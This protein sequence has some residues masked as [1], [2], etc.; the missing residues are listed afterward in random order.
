MPRGEK[1]TD[2][3]RYEKVESLKKDLFL[4]I[5]N[6]PEKIS[7]NLPV[8]FGHVMSALENAFPDIDDATHD[9]FI[10]SVAYR[11][12]I[13]SAEAKKTEFIEKIIRNAI[14]CKRKKTKKSTLKVFSGIKLMDVGKYWE[15]ISYFGDLWKYDARIGI[16]IAFCYYA[17]SED[18][19]KSSKNIN[20][21]AGRPSQYELASREILLELARAQPEI[22][23]LKQIDIRDT[24]IMDQAFWLMINKAL[25]WF[26]SERWFLKIGIAKAKND[27]NEI[28]RSDLLSYAIEKYTNDLDFMREYYYYKLEKRDAMG[29]SGIVKQM[30]QQNPDNLEPVYYG[31]KLS[32]LS[33]SKNTYNQYRKDALEKGIPHY[34]IQLYDLAIYIM[35][36]EK[37][38]ADLQLKL[39]KKKFKSL[40]FYLAVIEYLMKDIFSDDN[41]RKKA[42]KNVFFDSLDRYS[43]QVIKIQE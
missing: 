5:D 23:R 26:P 38:E 14:R 27:G 35:R 19:E 12:M 29:A 39:I 7:N 36:E 37:N 43:M 25:E 34:L 9:D 22:N 1:L 32:L 24:E 15:A 31:I 28:K 20:D 16:Y 30:I 2:A 21:P 4:Y 17:L 42:A 40:H 3:I 11:I 33:N 10:D 8:F 13:S 41:D 18:E 6:N